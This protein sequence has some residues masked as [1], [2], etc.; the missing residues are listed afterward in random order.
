MVSLAYKLRRTRRQSKDK[1]RHVVMGHI[2]TIVREWEDQCVEMGIHE[3][4][5]VNEP[6]LQF[7]MGVIHGGYAPRYHTNAKF[8]VIYERSFVIEARG[9]GKG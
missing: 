2:R 5:F 1:A 3:R 9:V 4:P 8:D 6:S 7:G